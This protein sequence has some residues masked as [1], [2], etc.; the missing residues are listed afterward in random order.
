MLS[1]VRCLEIHLY[2]CILHPHLYQS[3]HS[4]NP[5]VLSHEE[6]TASK[7]VI[8]SNM[9]KAGCS[10]KANRCSW[11]SQQGGNPGL[12]PVVWGQEQASKVEALGISEVEDCCTGTTVEQ[13]LGVEGS[14]DDRKG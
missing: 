1:A 12:T 2:I 9:C 8:E 4:T 5:V 7:I 10:S 14:V 6:N 11:Y 3:T 13:E